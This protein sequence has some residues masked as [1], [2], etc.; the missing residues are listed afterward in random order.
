MPRKTL[1]SIDLVPRA[2]EQYANST[3]EA[4]QL[5]KA[6][7]DHQDDETRAAIDGIVETLRKS[8]T[9]RVN[10]KV[11]GKLV[12]IKVDDLTLGYGLLNLAVQ[13][14]SD[15]ALT[16]LRLANFKFDPKVCAYCGTKIGR[17]R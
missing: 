2:T 7:Y 14:V 12:P 13:V 3:L 5:A 9:G 1:D 8:V 16:G 10:V 15:L 11:G 17:S 4:Y 6:T